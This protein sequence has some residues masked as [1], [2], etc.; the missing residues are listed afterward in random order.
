MKV[1]EHPF[2]GMKK[3]EKKPVSDNMEDPA[4]GATMLF[5]TDM[6]IWVQRGNHKVA[7]LTESAPESTFP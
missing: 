5:D 4:K 3:E 6:F 2:F 7:S 1:S